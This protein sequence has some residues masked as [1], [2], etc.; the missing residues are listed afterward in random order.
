MNIN[1]NHLNSKTPNN[2]FFSGVL[3]VHKQTTN[4]FFIYSGSALSSQA[5]SQALHFLKQT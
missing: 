5:S 3:T 4:K 1:V 2:W